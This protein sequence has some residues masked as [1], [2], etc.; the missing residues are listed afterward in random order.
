MYPEA[1]SKE[2]IHLRSDSYR[3]DNL[4]RDGY[5][6]A[7]IPSPSEGVRI[8]SASIVPQTNGQTITWNGSVAVGLRVEHRI[9]T[10][11]NIRNL[12]FNRCA[13]P[14]KTLS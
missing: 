7:V 5:A 2:R 13:L 3:S 10:A 1:S 6:D 8:S 4:L 11:V 9:P 12:L 14:W